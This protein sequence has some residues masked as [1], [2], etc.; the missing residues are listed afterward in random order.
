VDPANETKTG[1]AAWAIRIA[2]LGYPIALLVVWLALRFIG[3]R[4]WVTT[5]GLYM[6]LELLAAPL[7]LLAAILAVRGPR[8]LLLSQAAAL[9][10]LVPLLGWTWSFPGPATPGAPRLR[11]LT[12]NVDSDHFGFDGILRVIRE[13]QPDLVLLQEAAPD[14]AEELAPRLPG[15]DVRGSG[16]FAIASR[17]PILEQLEPPR[18]VY[19]GVSH[20]PRFMRYRLNGPA[21]IVQVYSVHPPSP[22][23]GLEDLRGEGLRHELQSGRLLENAHAMNLISRIAGLRMTQMR[24]VADDA[25]RSPYPVIIAGDTNLPGLSWAFHQTLGGFQDGFRQ[26]G[27]G[28]GYTFPATH[29]AWMRIDRILSDD[30]FRFL[31]CRVVPGRASDHHALVADLELRA[32]A[33]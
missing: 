14:E 11:V 29:H 7:P 31:G 1:V 33:R 16:Q 23:A 19:E 28:L 18:V 30:H 26:A 9:A 25:A 15:Y 32:A 22:R 8:R 5:V 27:R 20:S 2:A 6:P 21:G 24:A 10:L 13:A 17:W 3:E 12:F 4:W